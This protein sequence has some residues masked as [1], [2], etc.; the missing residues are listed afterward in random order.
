[1]HPVRRPGFTGRVSHA[2]L[3][4]LPVLGV[5]VHAYWRG[6]PE[7]REDLRAGRM[8]LLGAVL[9]GLPAGVLWWL[10]APRADYRVSEDGPVP[11]GRPSGELQIGDDAVLLFV[12]I[13]FG[14]LAGVVAWLLRRGRGVGMLLV[15]A[16]GA[17]LGAVVAWQTGTLLGAPPSEAQLAE[18]GAR[19]TTPLRLHSLPVLAAAPFAAL[20]V[21]LTGA[22]VAA[23]DGLGRTVPGGARPVGA[24]PRGQEP[25]R[26]GQRPPGW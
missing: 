9:A 11:I 23:D 26:P 25:G 5:P 3:P 7:V 16:V 19:V 24:P 15:L 21:Y 1:M 20:L 13:G 17:S 4:D 12:L 22:L 10:L 2:P 14:I 18:V 6:W 8:V